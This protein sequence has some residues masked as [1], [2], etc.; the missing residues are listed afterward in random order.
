M[1]MAQC[2]VRHD[3]LQ[4]GI[5]WRVTLHACPDQGSLVRFKTSGKGGR[6]LHQES[7]QWN[8]LAGATFLLPRERVAGGMVP[9]Y[10]VERIKATLRGSP[11]P[12]RR[13]ERIRCGGGWCGPGSGLPGVLK[14][15]YLCSSRSML[16]WWSLT[17]L[18]KASRF[19][20]G[21]MA[22][23]DAVI[24]ATVWPRERHRPPVM[25][26]TLPTSA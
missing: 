3:G 26:P 14:K 7:A 25:S 21:S 11:L 16:F 6:L 9:K 4:S 13:A 22:T 15:D 12:A 8:Q 19:L 17:Q 23:A 24:A 10:L 1:A 2:Q 20:G 5:R 18:V